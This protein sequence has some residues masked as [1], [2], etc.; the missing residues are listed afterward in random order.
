MNRLGGPCRG[1]SGDG[2]TDHPSLASIGCV[3]ARKLEPFVMCPYSGLIVPK[4]ECSEEHVLTKALGAKRG[5]CIDVHLPHNSTFGTEVDAKFVDSPAVLF[6]RADLGAK[7]ANGVPWFTQEI[8]V[9]VQ[10]Y[11]V[12]L[13]VERRRGERRIVEAFSPEIL[14]AQ[15]QPFGRVHF[16]KTHDEAFKKVA[17]AVEKRK[18]RGK[19]ASEG[20]RV[21]RIEGLCDLPD[22]THIVDSNAVGRFFAKVALGMTFK[23]FG[24]EW[25][26]S[27]YAEALR[28]VV[29]D[30]RD[31]SDAPLAAGV[32]QRD[33]PNLP[34]F[35]VGPDEHQLAFVPQPDGLWFHVTVFSLLSGTFR[36]MSSP[37]IR[38]PEGWAVNFQTNRVRPLK[39][40]LGPMSRS[41]S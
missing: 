21:D 11:K 30:E 37:T 41:E 20:P 15:G 8:V 40:V 16:G 2:L 19:P 22:P 39:P 18:Q 31:W 33:L 14:D 25:A 1:P 17:A 28:A 38:A 36:V 13:K 5:P 4:S 6:L 10:G 7:G 29:R 34:F 32:E 26:K 35:D 24:P 12:R 9:D 23:R 27:G 3:A